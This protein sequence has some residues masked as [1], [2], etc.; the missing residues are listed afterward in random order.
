MKKISVSCHLLVPF[1]GKQAVHGNLYDVLYYEFSKLTYKDLE[2]LLKC[3]L[4]FTLSHKLKI[5]DVYKTIKLA[6]PPYNSLKQLKTRKDNLEYYFS[7]FLVT[8]L[9]NGSGKRE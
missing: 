2:H 9:L 6:K 7:G 1:V 4:K 8:S 5:V 3:S